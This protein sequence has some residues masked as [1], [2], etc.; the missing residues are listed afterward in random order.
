L[1]PG[2][3][4]Y[5]GFKRS[6]TA[7]RLRSIVESNMPAERNKIEEIIRERTLGGGEKGLEEILLLQLL[8]NPQGT[9]DPNLL[10][11]LVLLLGGSGRRGRFDRL[12]LVAVLISQQQQQAQAAASASGVP[13]PLSNTLPLLLALGLF[14]E[15]REREVVELKKS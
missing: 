5:R 11:L 15:E 13:P 2:N 3:A 4:A 12:A 8:T 1:R 7:K 10:P 14:G 9:T 6:G